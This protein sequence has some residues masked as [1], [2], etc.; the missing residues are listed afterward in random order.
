MPYQ[1]YLT[2]RQIMKKLVAITGFLLLYTCVY[3]QDIIVKRDKK[4]LKVSIVEVMD[5]VVKYTIFEQPGGLALS[6]KKADIFMVI[7]KNGYREYYEDP[8]PEPAAAKKD[9]PKKKKGILKFLKKAK[10]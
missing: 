10:K 5:S 9:D 8:P 4:E 3:S 6:M 7:Y 2:K 1:I